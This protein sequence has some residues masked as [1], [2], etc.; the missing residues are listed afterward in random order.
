RMTPSVL[1]TVGGVNVQG[2]GYG[3]SIAP[4]PGVANEF[5]GLTDRG[6]N[7]DGPNGSKVFPLPD[8]NPKI[9]HFKIENGAAQLINTITLSDTTGKARTGLP[10]PPGPGNTGETALDLTGKTLPFDPQGLD[11]EGL[12]ALPDGTFWISDEYGPYIV[13]FDAS[14]RT[15]EQITPFAKTAQGHKLPSVLAKR[16]P[17]KGMEGLTITPDGTTLVGIMQSALINDISQ[18][19]AGRTAPVRIVTLN[20]ATGETHQYVYLLEDPVT[21]GSA[22]SEITAVSNTEFLVDER[23]GKFPLDPATT[24]QLKKIWQI[25]LTGATDVSDPTDSEKGLLISGQTLEALVNKQ[26]TAQAL[27]TLAANNIKPVTKTL[28]VDLVALLASL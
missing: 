20:L 14:G 27:S 11:T 26:T 13:H 3:S 9:G 2:D 21:T 8:F 24:P 25:S 23:D 18:S 4:V 5:Y 1:T 15:L 17:N 16:I 7:V 22:N 28:K 6:P 10:N 19:D 12:A